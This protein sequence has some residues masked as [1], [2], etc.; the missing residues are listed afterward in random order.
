LL[1][2]ITESESGEA[3]FW[4]RYI[5]NGAR[6]WI[7]KKNGAVDVT[8]KLNERGNMV[9]GSQFYQHCKPVD[10]L[11]LS[12]SWTSWAY[13]DDPELDRGSI[14]Q[15]ALIHF[16]ASGQFTDEGILILHCNITGTALL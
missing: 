1:N 8:V 4:S 15:K 3:Q 11:R 5:N 12:G 10:G 16:S 13:P 7:I 2:S 14:G 9:I 6:N